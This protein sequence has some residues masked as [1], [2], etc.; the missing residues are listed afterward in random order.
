MPVA[1]ILSGVGL[2]SLIF[3][4]PQISNKFNLM[5]YKFALFFV[6]VSYYVKYINAYEIYFNYFQLIILFLTAMYTLLKYKFN[7]KS[8]L[9]VLFCDVVYFCLVSLDI[10]FI[11]SYNEFMFSIIVLIPLIITLNT[12]QCV[13]LV[14]LNLLTMGAIDIRFELFE[15]SFCVVNSNLFF[16]LV[17]ICLLIN[18]IQK[19]F[20]RLIKFKK[21]NYYE[22]IGCDIFTFNSNTC[23]KFV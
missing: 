21:D 12:Y 4:I 11:I 10:S 6:L 14:I 15:F 3:N 20:F 8:L 16:E 7:L 13:N 1:F 18:F 22:K 23:N 2:I 5:L 9:I 17:F 19:M